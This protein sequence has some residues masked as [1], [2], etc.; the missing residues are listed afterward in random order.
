MKGTYGGHAHNDCLS[1][2]IWHE[3]SRFLTD[4]GTYSYSGDPAARNQFRST[5]SHNTAR[6]DGAEIN[7]FNRSLL[8]AMENDARP[9]VLGWI[10]RPDFDYLRAEHYGYARLKSPVVHRRS[11]FW[12]RLSGFI[13][14]ED[15]FEGEGAHLFELFFHFFPDI[16]VTQDSES[17]F[18][19]TGSSS[20]IRLHFLSAD[21]WASDLR[22]CFVSERY[23]LR[24][25]AS[26]I[27][28]TSSQT[29]PLTF[30]TA[31]DLGSCG[32]GDPGDEAVKKRLDATF[33]RYGEIAG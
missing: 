12:D 3:G 5:E 32:Q 7:R 6:V 16:E 23:G 24:R 11:L 26:K 25:P 18:R 19:A 13:L 29:A 30:R 9:R 27:V 28:L 8:F 33:R 17:T 21:G 10:T 1:F 14:V 22:T 31:I 2:E 15:C 20:T 4:C